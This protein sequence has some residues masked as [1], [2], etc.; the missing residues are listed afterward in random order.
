MVCHRFLPTYCPG[1]EKV[2]EAQGGMALVD[3]VPGAAREVKRRLELHLWMA[4]WDAYAIAGAVLEQ[5]EYKRAQLHKAIVLEQAMQAEASGQGTLVGV[6]YDE[7]AR[8]CL[9]SMACIN[10]LRPMCVFF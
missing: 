7:F 2:V 10:W 6:L 4:A 3:L 8:L 9:S 1:H 5:F